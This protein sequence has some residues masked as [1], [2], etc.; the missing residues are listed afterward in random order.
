[1]PNKMNPGEVRGGSIYR[2]F[3]AGLH[4]LECDRASRSLAPYHSAVGHRPAHWLIVEDDALTLTTAGLAAA[5]DA[6]QEAVRG[7]AKPSARSSAGV[8]GPA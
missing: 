5:L 2:A 8:A 7:P 4:R 6:D 3:R 1:M